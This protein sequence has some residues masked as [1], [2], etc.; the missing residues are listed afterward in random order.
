MRFFK[1]LFAV[2]LI[3]IGF[4]IILQNLQIIS[5][6]ISSVVWDSWPVIFVVLGFLLFVNYFRRDKSGSWLFGLFLIVFGILLWLGNF[7]VYDFTFADVWKLWPIILIYIGA[8]ILFGKKMVSVQVVTNEESIKKNNKSRTSDQWVE[9]VVDDVVD[10]VDDVVK[11]VND[12]VEDLTD[13]VSEKDSSFND[14]YSNNEA[15]ED[16]KSE[17]KKHSKQRTG[18][19]K[20]HIDT[21]KHFVSDINLSKDNWEVESMDLW[22][23]VGDVYIDFSKGYIPD[24][25]S[26]ITLKG[27]IADLVVKVPEHVAVKIYGRVNIGEVRIF[28]EVGSGFNNAVSYE[29]E[30]Y[31]QATRKLNIYASYQIG[32]IQILSV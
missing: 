29:S 12:V 22:S 16:K 13:S 17:R 32:D 25:E 15:D 4:T 9:E 8:K 10:E 6:E 31:D 30:G 19:Y 20:Y 28:E 3:I 18:K 21:G 1:W 23:V 11:G 26:F 7:G 24:E 27:Y 14:S 5:V 2:L